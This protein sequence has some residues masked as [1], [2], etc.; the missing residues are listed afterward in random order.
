MR[1][2]YPFRTAYFD[3]EAPVNESALRPFRHAA[4]G[5]CFALREDTAFDSSPQPPA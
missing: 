4:T 5:S 1:E 2:S 3:S